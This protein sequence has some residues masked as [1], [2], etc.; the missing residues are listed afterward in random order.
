MLDVTDTPGRPVE[1]TPD[2]LD[3]KLGSVPVELPVVLPWVDVEPETPELSG[4]GITTLPLPLPV[5]LLGRTG[6]LAV[7]AEEERELPALPEEVETP[8][9]AF[10]TDVPAPLD[11][12]KPIET[13]PL[14][15][16]PVEGPDPLMLGTT[17]S[18]VPD[19]LTTTLVATECPTLVGA[20]AIDVIDEPRDAGA[21]GTLGNDVTIGGFEF[22]RIPEGPKMIPVPV[23]AVGAD[24]VADEPVARGLLG[25]R[26]VNG[27]TP[28][29]ATD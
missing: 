19:G 13:E 18:I 22:E 11:V 17:E 28:P 23:T 8:V 16:E 9:D 7:L 5:E 24:A 4:T 10:E 25:D 2:R 26:I 3:S 29:D 14:D 15:A 21:P 6:E 12:P 20:E 27:L 1:V